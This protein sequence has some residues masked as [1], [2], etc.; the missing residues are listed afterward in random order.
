MNVA[1]PVYVWKLD[2]TEAE[3]RTYQ[4]SAVRLF[5]GSPTYTEAI[6]A[7]LFYVRTDSITKGETSNTVFYQ[8]QRSLSLLRKLL[9]RPEENAD[10]ITWTSICFLV[11]NHERGDWDVYDI[12]VRGLRSFIA[13]IGGDEALEKRSLRAYNFS[14][15]LTHL[16]PNDKDFETTPSPQL[17]ELSPV[18]VPCLD[19]HSA[20]TKGLAVLTKCYLWTHH[21][22]DPTES[23]SVPHEKLK[24]EASLWKIAMSNQIPMSN[25]RLLCIGV[26]IRLGSMPLFESSGGPD[27]MTHSSLTKLCDVLQNSIDTISEH[28]RW[29]Y[30]LWTCLVVLVMGTNVALVFKQR[31]ALCKA[32]LSEDILCLEWRNVRPMLNDVY[33]DQD[34]ERVCRTSWESILRPAVT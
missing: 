22:L 12:H 4:D 16:N 19:M 28:C 11:L 6:L 7:W 2:T 13:A 33:L 15:W 26:L 31:I 5:L 29:D 30:V 14:Q 8:Q 34:M 27:G 17:D 10:A 20:F 3:R 23:E 21:N 24:I 18:D 32:L 9:S 25:D 1:G